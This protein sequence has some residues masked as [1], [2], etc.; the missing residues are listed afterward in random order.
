MQDA[1]LDSEVER[2]ITALQVCRRRATLQFWIALPLFALCKHQQHHTVYKT[3][4]QT[5]HAVQH[6]RHV[7][8]CNFQQA[9]QAS[10]TSQGGHA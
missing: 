7:S 10:P 9:R 3:A 6:T 8:A 4:L 2:A 5:Y 1:Y